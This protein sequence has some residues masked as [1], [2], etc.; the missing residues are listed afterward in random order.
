MLPYWRQ[1][2]A[3]IIFLCFTNPNPL[4]SALKYLMLIYL[5]NAFNII[6]NFLIIELH[7]LE[8]EF[9]FCSTVGFQKK[10]FT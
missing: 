4:P 10:Q 8:S 1:D 2:H 7:F 3:I 9:C 5:L 6:E